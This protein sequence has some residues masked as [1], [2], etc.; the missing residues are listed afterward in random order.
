[1]DKKEQIILGKTW[2]EWERECPAV[3]DM[4]NLRETVWIR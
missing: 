1:M 2:E 4:L 3:K